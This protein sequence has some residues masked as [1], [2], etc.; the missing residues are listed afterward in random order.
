MHLDICIL[1][2][3][4]YIYIWLYMYMQ[5]HKCAF[6]R[7]RFFANLSGFHSREPHSSS[8]RQFSRRSAAQIRCAESC[9]AGW[10]NVASTAGM[11]VWYGFNVE[12]YQ[13]WGFRFLDVSKMVLI[14][15]QWLD[16]TI[17]QTSSD[18]F[19]NSAWISR[20]GDASHLRVLMLLC[21]NGCQRLPGSTLWSPSSNG[22]LGTMQMV[23]SGNLLHNYGKWL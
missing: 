16:A 13:E 2:V 11:F 21:F 10:K 4:I 7:V 8:N 12:C 18:L 3:Y 14:F 15:D 17:Q 19:C 20:A 5:L 6:N 23:P 1:Y 22:N 9:Q